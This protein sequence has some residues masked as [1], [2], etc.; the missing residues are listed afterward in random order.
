MVNGLLFV[1]IIFGI[2]TLE[3]IYSVKSWDS[4]LVLWDALEPNLSLM[5]LGLE[6]AV[7]PIIGW[8]VPEAAM[9]WLLEAVVL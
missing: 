1:A 9:I 5:L 2:T 6:N 7:Q 8:I 3:S 4:R